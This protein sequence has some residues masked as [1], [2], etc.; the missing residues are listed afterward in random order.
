MKQ[1]L[2]SGTGVRKG[3]VCYLVG[4]SHNYGCRP[5]AGPAISLM[6]LIRETSLKIGQRTTIKGDEKDPSTSI[7]SRKGALTSLR[8]EQQNDWTFAK[9]VLGLG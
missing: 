9:Y 6:G 4:E 8:G 5:K 3:R 7:E 1:P 2:N